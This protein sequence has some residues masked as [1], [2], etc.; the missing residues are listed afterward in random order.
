MYW[1]SSWKSGLEVLLLLLAYCFQ[2]ETQRECPDT[3]SI[4]YGNGA[5]THDAQGGMPCMGKGPMPPM[6]GGKRYHGRSSCFHHDWRKISIV[7]SILLLL[8]LKIPCLFSSLRFSS[9]MQEQWIQWWVCDP[10]CKCQKPRHPQFAGIHRNCQR[11]NAAGWFLLRFLFQGLQ[12]WGRHKWTHSRSCNLSWD[13][14]D[15]MRGK[16]SRMIDGDVSSHS[17]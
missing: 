11:M 7:S 8:H 10:T 5:G 6:P 14:A 13:C 2:H 15:V 12:W 1:V 17:A 3:W 16:G 9:C 4:G